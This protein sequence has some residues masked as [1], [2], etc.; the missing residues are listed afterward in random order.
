MP[1]ARVRAARSA[2]TAAAVSGVTCSRPILSDSERQTASWPSR[3]TSDHRSG[4]GSD[5]VSRF[6]RQHERKRK[7]RPNDL[8][9]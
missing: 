5:A 7:L 1:R 9:Y 3:S 8:R 6:S 2:V 4:D